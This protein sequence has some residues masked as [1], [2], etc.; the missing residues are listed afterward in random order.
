MFADILLFYCM[1]KRNKSN[2]IEFQSPLNTGLF[3]HQMLNKMTKMVEKIDV[4][5][6]EPT[7]QNVLA[8][9]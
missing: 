9:S 7:W 6:P 1:K 5:G 3:R 4:K 8:S 2:L